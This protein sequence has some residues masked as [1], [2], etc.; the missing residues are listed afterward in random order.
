M[1]E[2]N[3]SDEILAGL[4]AGGMSCAKAA[5]KIGVHE[6]TVR[7]RLEDPEFRK[8]VDS[9]KSQVVSEAVAVLGRTM[10]EAATTLRRLLRSKNEGI[11]LGAARSVIELHLKAHTQ[12]DLEEQLRQ[13]QADIASIKRMR[14]K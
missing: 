12:M 2:G 7:R 9:I 6:R 10:V 1:P 8:L 3:E 4:L 11:R 14:G 13:V 5:Q